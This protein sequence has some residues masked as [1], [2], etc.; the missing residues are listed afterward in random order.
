MAEKTSTDSVLAVLVMD[1]C[2]S[3]MGHTQIR[4][5]L[6]LLERLGMVYRS[7]LTKEMVPKHFKG[8]MDRHG[9]NTSLFMNLLQG[10][11]EL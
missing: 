5:S 6:P 1:G 9:Q 7:C 10:Y 8:A 11:N 3:F 2:C 4:K